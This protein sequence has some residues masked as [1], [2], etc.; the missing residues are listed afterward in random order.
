MK[1]PRWWEWIVILMIVAIAGAA[2]FPV[3]AV[4]K[5]GHRNPCLSNLKQIGLGLIM[6]ASDYDGRPPQRDHWMDAMEAYTK[7]PAIEHCDLV[8]GTGLYGYALNAGVRDMSEG[9]KDAATEPLAYDS[10][11]LARNASDLFNSL[12]APGRHQ[13]G[14]FVV[15]AD[16]H[17]KF[18]KSK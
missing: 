6:Y 12:P 15:Y 11:N 5:D 8:K 14:N 16:G 3:F 13:G 10:V 2:L 1:W 4:E 17:A 9:A 18:L 7:N